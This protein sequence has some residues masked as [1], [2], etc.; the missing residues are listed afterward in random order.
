MQDVEHILVSVPEEVNDIVR[1]IL[2]SSLYAEDNDIPVEEIITS[3]SDPSG[4][5]LPQVR[6]FEKC[7][8]EFIKTGNVT[9]IGQDS[10]LSEFHKAFIEDIE[11]Q[12]SVHNW[13]V[14]HVDTLS[15]TT[16]PHL[17]ILTIN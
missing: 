7:L 4:E 2:I 17:Y 6:Q 5:K 16:I 1:S 14:G 13:S 9:C 8:L 12:I 3:D 11:E 10:N 15:L